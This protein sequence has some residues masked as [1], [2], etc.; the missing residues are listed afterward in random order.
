MKKQVTKKERERVLQYLNATEIDDSVICC[1]LRATGW[2]Q[3]FGGVVN[4]KIKASEYQLKN[5]VHILVRLREP[6]DIPLLLSALKKWHTPIRLHILS[7]LAKIGP[8]EEALSVLK[9]I[10]RDERAEP[11]E[12]AY[13]LQALARGADKALIAEL[14]ENPPAHTE[15][16]GVWESLT[17]LRASAS[18]IGP[19]KFKR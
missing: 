9:G 5:A 2:K 3:I 16:S 10:V 12:I 11:P 7:A 8:D 18:A 15:D 1:V 14:K 4:G 17:R 19:K 6:E 13:A